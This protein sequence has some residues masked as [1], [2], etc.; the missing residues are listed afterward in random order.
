MKKKV[1][2]D[3]VEERICGLMD[4]DTLQQLWDMVKV[5]R[6]ERIF[7]SDACCVYVTGTFLVSKNFRERH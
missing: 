2:Y 6:T 1:Q 4:R 5:D 7:V 3:E